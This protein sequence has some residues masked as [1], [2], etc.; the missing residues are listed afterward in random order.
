MTYSGDIL[1]SQQFN[2]DIDATFENGQ[3]VMTDGFESMVILAVFGE[4]G[5][6]NAATDVEGERFTSTFPALIRRA[7]VSD[8][9]RQ[10]GEKAIE[11]ALAFMMDEKMADKVSCTGRF[12]D[13][14]SIQWEVTINGP[15]SNSKYSINWQKGSLTA[16]ISKL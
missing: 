9:T 1:L 13:A 14:R 16:T 10:D 6:L 8:E 7:S 5:I 4:P 11:K 3:P 2:G 12:V 15:T